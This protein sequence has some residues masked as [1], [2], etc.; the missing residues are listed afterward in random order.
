MILHDWKHEKN[1]FICKLRE[2]AKISRS[3]FSM[4]GEKIIIIYMHRC[5]TLLEVPRRRLREHFKEMPKYAMHVY[6]E[7]F[8]PGD[9]LTHMACM[10]FEMTEPRLW[11]FNELSTVYNVNDIKALFETRFLKNYSSGTSDRRHGPTHC[12]TDSSWRIRLKESLDRMRTPKQYRHVEP[13]PQCSVNRSRI[14]TTSVVGFVQKW[15]GATK[16]IEQEDLMDTIPDTKAGWFIVK[17]DISSNINL[18]K[19]LD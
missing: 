3:E 18:T 2:A 17:Y 19:A 4:K 1:N 9:F 12:T 6:L 11:A 14:Q 16:N 7:E 5:R 15:D 13:K 10:L 8:R